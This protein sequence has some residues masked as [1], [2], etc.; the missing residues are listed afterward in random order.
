MKVAQNR[1]VPRHFA[2]GPMDPE[3]ALGV[4]AE[5]E[6]ASGIDVGLRLEGDARG[7]TDRRR[8]GAAAPSPPIPTET[9]AAAARREPHLAGKLAGAVLSPED[10]QV[11]N[12]KLAGA[13]RVAARCPWGAKSGAVPHGSKP[14]MLLRSGRARSGGTQ[15]IPGDVH[16]ERAAEYSL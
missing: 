8:P 2:S 7:R 13:L 1:A 3:G 14:R 4:A 15:I 9:R 11:D 12:R 5:L 16:G 6:Q 10:T